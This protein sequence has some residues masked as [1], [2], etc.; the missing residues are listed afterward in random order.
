LARRLDA[1][2]DPESQQNERSN[3]NPMDW[4]VKD[5]G[6]KNK[7][8]NDEDDPRNI[9][10]EG[11]GGD[12]PMHEWGLTRSRPLAVRIVLAHCPGCAPGASEENNPGARKEDMF[13]T[14]AVVLLVLWGLGFLAFHVTSGLIHLL[15]LAAVIVFV[16]QLVSGRRSAG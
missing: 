10:S 2:Q 9:D 7:A 4:R 16:F 8:A 3:D 14:I 13:F 15:L 12:G 11:H 1:R 5:G 6:S